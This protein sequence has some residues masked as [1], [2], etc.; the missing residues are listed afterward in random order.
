MTTP[1]SLEPPRLA[2]WLLER[3]SLVVKNPPLAGDLIEAFKEGRSSSWYWR[4]VFW[5]IAVA[6]LDLLQRQWR[7]L[8]YAVACTGL[9]T[10]GWFVMVPQAGRGSAVPVIFA[11]YAMGYRISWPWSLAYQI[12][13]STTFQA[14]IVV[15]ALGVYLAFSRTLRLRH[16]LRASIVVCVVMGVGNAGLP[17]LAV[18]LNSM[19]VRL[20]FGWFVL[21]S[22]PTMVALL[23]G[24]WK[25]RQQKT[26][27]SPTW[28]EA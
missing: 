23:L 28:S 1:N 2:T 13:F 19:G 21:L 10:A 20:T 4:Q 12:A 16:L 3:F 14:V 7:S 6:S 5:A 22:T 27:S 25:A 26:G 24:I 9:T 17:F 11:L 15:F 18:A 8:A